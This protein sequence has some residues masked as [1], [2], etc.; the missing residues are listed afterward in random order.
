MLQEDDQ[1]STSELCELFQL[2]SIILAQKDGIEN[3]EINL[4][5]IGKPLCERCRRY[6]EPELSKLCARCE[7][8]LN[9]VST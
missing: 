6:P 5:P 9:A 4:V 1:S 7:D 2:S 8:V 3:A